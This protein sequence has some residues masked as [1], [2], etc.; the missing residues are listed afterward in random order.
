[1]S[2]LRS[3]S[4]FTD[5]KK[6]LYVSNESERSIPQHCILSS[7]T[8]HSRSVPLRYIKNDNIF[9]F[10]ASSKGFKGTVVSP[11]RYYINGG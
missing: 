3:N 9:S 8:L 6:V 1:M 2:N 11:T 5:L 4:G 10:F 7:T